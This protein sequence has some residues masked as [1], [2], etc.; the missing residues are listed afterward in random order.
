M[1]LNAP[2]YEGEKKVAQG[3]LEPLKEPEK[4]CGITQIS[5]HIFRVVIDFSFHCYLRYDLYE[6]I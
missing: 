6:D 2:F 5:G 3:P 4:E 1:P